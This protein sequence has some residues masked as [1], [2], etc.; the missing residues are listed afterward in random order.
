MAKVEKQ[1]QL[2]GKYKHSKL[3]QNKQILESL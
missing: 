2:Y 3:L 1:F